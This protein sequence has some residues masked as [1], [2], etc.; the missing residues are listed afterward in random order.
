MGNEEVQLSHVPELKIGVLGYLNRDGKTCMIIK[1]DPNHYMHGYCVAPGGK[2]EPN[3]TLVQA[4]I[5]EVEEET[6]IVPINPKFKGTLSFPDYGKS[7]FGAE[8][9]CF[10]FV[11]EDYT[12]IPLEIGA[13]GKVIF[14]DIEDLPK[15]KM[16]QGDEIFTPHVFSSG[17]FQFV[18]CSGMGA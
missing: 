15:Q 7:P 6:G 2:R 9:L 5:R 12:G 18:F 16:W 14:L 8:W 17:I 4:V 1:D 13:E 3:E 11:F 10:V